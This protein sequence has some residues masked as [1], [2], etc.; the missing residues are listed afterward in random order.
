MKETLKSIQKIAFV[1]TVLV[2]TIV[3]LYVAGV[4]YNN[5]VN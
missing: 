2:V 1:V 5:L 3:V 4:V